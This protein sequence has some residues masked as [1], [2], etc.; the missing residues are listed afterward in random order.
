[1]SQTCSAQTC[2]PLTTNAPVFLFHVR[3]KIS[4]ECTM[5]GKKKKNRNTKLPMFPSSSVM[6]Y[7]PHPRTA[8]QTRGLFQ[9]PV[10]DLKNVCF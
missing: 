7:A 10:S 4:R 6:T 1:M 5:P 9:L 3:H 2:F 8:I